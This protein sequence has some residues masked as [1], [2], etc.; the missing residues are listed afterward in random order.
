[1]ISSLTRAR[2]IAV[3]PRARLAPLVMVT[4][5]V[6]IASLAV[7][8]LPI[9]MAAMPAIVRDALLGR[10]AADPVMTA[11]LLEVR[12][13]RALFALVV[14]GALGS[15]GACMQGLFRNPLADPTLIGVSPGAAL[16]AAVTIVLGGRIAPGIDVSHLLPPAAF[17]GALAIT[18]AM[19]RLGQ[20]G[21]NT[22]VAMVLLTGVAMSALAM[23]GVGLLVLVADD[24]QLRDLTFWNLGSLGG[25]TWQSLGVAALFA[26]PVMLYLPR[27][28]G[29]LDAWLLGDAEAGHLGVDVESLKRRAILLTALGVG[30]AVAFA[31]IIGFVGLVVPHVLRL[32]WGP[33]HRALLPGAALLGAALLAGA[34]TAARTIAAPTEVPI[35]ILTALCG[36]PFFV[37]LVRRHLPRGLA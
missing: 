22:S 4:A 12:L 28:A 20:R 26:L 1:M 24:R 34:D 32:V 11:V 7:G 5:A 2:P 27:L 19:W 30:A 35:G 15:T 8:A 16:A 25:A 13:P 6:T 10:E 29:P 14:G 31:G 21:G 33:S 36:A 23:A 18:I 9:P 17:L 37:W 3:S